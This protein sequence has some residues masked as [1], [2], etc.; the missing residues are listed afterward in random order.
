MADTNWV[1][2]AASIIHLGA[3]LVFAGV[4]QDSWC[5][6]SNSWKRQLFRPEQCL[7][8]GLPLLRQGHGTTNA[9][10]ILSSQ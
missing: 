7:C 4:L 9:A 3:T 10:R 5:L 8:L 2:T 1:A 6:V